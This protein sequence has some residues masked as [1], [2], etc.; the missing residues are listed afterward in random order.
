MILRFNKN[1]FTYSVSDDMTQVQ[2]SHYPSPQEIYSLMEKLV[3]KSG[4]C[5]TSRF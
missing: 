3:Y 1:L 4:I 2:I 5:F